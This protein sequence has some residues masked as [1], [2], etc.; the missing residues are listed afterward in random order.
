MLRHLLKLTWKRKSRNLL[1][2]AE[3]LL[4]FLI[5]FAIAATGVRY[6]QLYDKPLGFQYQ[7]VWAV[8]LQ[9]PNGNQLG[10]TEGM[11]E[12]FVRALQSM[13]Q[14]ENVG[15]TT[16]P[17]FQDA[18]MVSRIALA[19][20]SRSVRANMIEASDQFWAT[21]GMPLAAGRWPSVQDEGADALATVITRRMA[22]ELFPDGSPLGQVIRAEASN[23]TEAQRFRVVGVVE[24][25][26]SHGE[27]MAPRAFMLYRYVP[28]A[29]NKMQMTLLLKVRPGT[30]RA[31]EPE[32]QRQLKQ[33][34][35]DWAFTINPLAELRA[36]QL[37]MALVPLKVLGVI[38]AFLLAMVCF[39]LFGVL[40][41][42][43]TRRIPEIGLRRAVG[44][45]AGAIYRQ[46]VAEQL[47]LSSLAMA[48]GLALLVQLPLTGAL[49]EALDWGVFAGGA[50]LS[51][52][53]IYL[54]SL[55]CSLYP[56]W[57]ASRLHPAMALHY[58]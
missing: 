17:L 21:L 27:F 37:T 49:G 24:D 54:L 28:M 40:W 41:Q 19:D 52:A 38:A 1:L 25:F 2:S 39:G 55:L 30:P 23:P 8:Q 57:R 4:A 51:M 6:W 10:R 22:Q 7:D 3:I 29:G 44:A 53:V 9:P 13:P 12:Q 5:V 58:E 20:G 16:F 47:L 34:R 45:S 26:R 50:A 42:N 32:L 33:V 35:N 36:S 14:V 11:H 48:A 15:I 18:S 46:I 56:G 43:T 31:F